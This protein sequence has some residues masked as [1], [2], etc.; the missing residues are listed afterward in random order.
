[1]GDVIIRMLKLGAFAA[2]FSLFH[3]AYDWWPSAITAVF[4]G[5]DESVFQHM[6]TGYFAWLAASALESLAARPPRGLRL[7]FAAVRLWGAFLVVYLFVS[8]WYLGPALVG[9][10]PSDAAE[11]ALAFSSVALGGLAALGLEAQLG[12]APL[13]RGLELGAMAAT[14]LAL[15]LFARF[16]ATRPWIDL[17]ELPPPH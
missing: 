6:K 14:L 17:F 13:S 15:Y 8:L 3:F 11:L 1:M 4:S 7:G 16:T 12:K 2:L 5:V 9:P 10:M